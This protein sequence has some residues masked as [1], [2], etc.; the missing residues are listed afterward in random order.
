[1]S[2]DVEWEG[3]FSGKNREGWIHWRLF[4]L[5]SGSGEGT[6]DED[7]F[8]WLTDDIGW[9]VL[10]ATEE[11][12]FASLAKALPAASFNYETGFDYEGGGLDQ[13]YHTIE[14]ANGQLFLSTLHRYEIYDEDNKENEKA[15]DWDEDLNCRVG[16]DRTVLSCMI[17]KAG[18]IVGDETL[19]REC[20]E[21]EKVQL[22]EL[23]QLIETGSYEPMNLVDLG[24][25]FETGLAGVERDLTRAWT[26]YL[27]AAETGDDE[28]V[29]FASEIFS[30]ESREDLLK[31]LAGKCITRELL[32]AFLDLAAKEN[33]AELTAILTEY[34]AVLE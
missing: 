4:S 6:D 29:E 11:R 18:F 33:N 23:L 9:D 17:D 20:L 13:I 14:Y 7:V 10:S 31:L 2:T 19:S 8:N 3:G 24:L 15:D 22:S 26:Y 30:E 27:Q 34:K 21:S 12:I 1:M 5:L 32:P 16:E 25:L 28:A